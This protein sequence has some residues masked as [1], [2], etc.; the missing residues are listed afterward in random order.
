MRDRK[1]NVLIYGLK[2]VGQPHNEN[3][4][5]VELVEQ[6]VPKWHIKTRKRLQCKN[7]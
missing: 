7:L 3:T 4:E 2:E 5:L 6:I 1:Y